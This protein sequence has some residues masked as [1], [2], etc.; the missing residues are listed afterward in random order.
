MKNRFSLALVALLIIALTVPVFVSAQQQR[1][2]QTGE[3]ST[4]TRP[5]G[6]SARRGLRAPRIMGEAY[7][8]ILDGL[9]ARGWA[10]PRRPIHLP[11]SRL[12]WIIMRHA[13]I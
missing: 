3:P 10:H 12:L 13:F 8:L 6:P 11:R 1:Q 4:T 9:V 2:S 5:T 7:R